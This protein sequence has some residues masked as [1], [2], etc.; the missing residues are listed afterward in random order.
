MG[1]PASPFQGWL[2][3]SEWKWFWCNSVLHLPLSP[4]GMS[5]IYHFREALLF[6]VFDLWRI[7]ICNATWFINLWD[8][9]ITFS[10]A[11]SSLKLQACFFPSFFF[12]KS[13]WYNPHYFFL[14]KLL[15]LIFH[16][17]YFSWTNYLLT[18][19]CICFLSELHII[20]LMESKSLIS[21]IALSH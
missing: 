9:L 21:C 3:H 14:F 10:C 2:P 5:L 19:Y 11:F 12:S 8:N 17:G 13:F 18:L 4:C 15:L 16:R 6:S 1:T 7:I 20:F